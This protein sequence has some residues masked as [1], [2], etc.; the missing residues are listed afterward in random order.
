M[1]EAPLLLPLLQALPNLTSEF[2]K[3][4][5]IT[6]SIISTVTSLDNKGSHPCAIE[7]ST[8]SEKTGVVQ[9]VRIL[10]TCESSQKRITF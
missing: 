8:K 7:Y 3:E 4:N 5:L 2:L 1:T 6:E 10:Q 9:Q